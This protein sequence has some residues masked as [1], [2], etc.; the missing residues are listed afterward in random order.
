M[1]FERTSAKMKE[2]GLS[3]WT[4]SRTL[5]GDEL[6]DYLNADLFSDYLLLAGYALECVLKGCL[7]SQRP[8][9]VNSDKKLDGL[10][11]THNL[12]QLCRSCGIDLSHQEQQLAEAMTWQILW[13]KYP[14]PKELK[15]MPSPVEQTKPRLDVRGSVF[16]DRQVK[17]VVDG[18]YQRVHDL[19]DSMRKPA[20]NRPH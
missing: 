11:T 14:A 13:G 8:E 9:L 17:E 7:L 1:E 10:V 12:A 18:L 16:H 4:E 3:S 15:D 6:D 20:P 5:E 2:K 19:L